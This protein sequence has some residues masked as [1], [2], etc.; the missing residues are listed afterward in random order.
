MTSVL[1]QPT[2]RVL[3]SYTLLGRADDQCAQIRF[4]AHLNGQPVTWT[5]K[6][7]TLRHYFE[8]QVRP[9]LA[10][11]A[12]SATVHPF[13]DVT[14]AL[15][16]EMSARVALG[17]AVVDEPTLRKVVVMMR[18]YKLLRPGKHEFSPAAM[19]YID[20]SEASGGP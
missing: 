14:S 2:T 4:A 5:V 7:M 8:V 1:N 18:Q 19:F 15:G 6:V 16:S 3:P 12:T 13:I 9:T 11:D 17:V 20:D 10:G